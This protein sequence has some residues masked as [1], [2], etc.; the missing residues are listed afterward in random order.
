MHK[1]GA[2]ILLFLHICKYYC[3]FL[4]FFSYLGER[5][6]KKRVWKGIFYIYTMYIYVGY[7]IFALSYGDPMVILWLSYGAGSF[8]ARKCLNSVPRV[9]LAYRQQL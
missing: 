2:K 3:I 6:I 7:A 1:S 9:E 4:Q 5:E 8:I